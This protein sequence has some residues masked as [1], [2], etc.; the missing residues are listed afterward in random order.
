MLIWMVFDIGLA[1]NGENTLG[2]NGKIKTDALP[3]KIFR[4]SNGW[5]EFSCFPLIALMK[6]YEINQD[7]TFLFF[8]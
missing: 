1:Q 7:N 5:V 4:I 2:N 6:S 3:E 8:Q